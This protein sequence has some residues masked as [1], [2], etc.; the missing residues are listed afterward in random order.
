[1]EPAAIVHLDNG[2]RS[3]HPLAV[4]KP[5]N[6][7]KPPIASAMAE[8]VPYSAPRKEV[9]E[10]LKRSRSA[11]T[12]KFVSVTVAN[13]HP[14]TTVTETRKSPNNQRSKK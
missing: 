14:A 9:M 13:K 10:M 7:N 4:R 8:G 12:G 3:P 2:K 5:F 1:M 11:K 6:N